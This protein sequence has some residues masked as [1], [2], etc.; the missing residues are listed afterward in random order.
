MTMRRAIWLV[1][2]LPLLGTVAWGQAPE[3]IR[4]GLWQFS[5]QGDDGTGGL[6][7][8]A[9]GQ[10][11]SLGSSF[12]S[13]IDP[14]R[15][16]PTDPQVP[17]QVEGMR[18]NGS[19]VSWVSTCSVPQGTFRSQGVAQYRGDT[20]QGTLTTEVPILG[21]QVTQRLSGRYLGPCTR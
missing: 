14:A 10:G 12:T 9:R 18:R 16:I 7:T 11:Q 2:A 19:S 4:A 15:T 20:M 17:C 8:A 21:G 6:F 1:A 5:S 3:V 13:C